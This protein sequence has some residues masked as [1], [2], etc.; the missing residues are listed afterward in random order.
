MVYNELLKW[1]ELK[2]KKKRNKKR[3]YLFIYIYIQNGKKVALKDDVV[4]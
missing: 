2:K 1:N 4:S 3:G